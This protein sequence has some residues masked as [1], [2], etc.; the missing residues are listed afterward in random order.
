MDAKASMTGLASKAHRRPGSLDVQGEGAAGL[1]GR[2][3]A[4]GRRRPLYE[5]RDRHEGPAVDALRQGQELP[6]AE[7]GRQ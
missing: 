7:A 2:G 4:A 5:A 1:G 3:H 6:R